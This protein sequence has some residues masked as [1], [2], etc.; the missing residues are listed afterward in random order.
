MFIQTEETPNP[1]TLKFMPG[2]DVMGD[3]PPADFPNSAAAENSPLAQTLF[4][5]QHVSSVFLGR[6]FITV[7]KGD[8]EWQH[9]KPHV[10]TAIMDFFCLW[11]SGDECRCRFV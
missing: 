10:L 11:P 8:A 6:D 4:K 5:V 7:T 2:R 3:A 9:V 1:M